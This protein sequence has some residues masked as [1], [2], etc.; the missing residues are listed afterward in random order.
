MEL[1]DFLEILK[2]LYTMDIKHNMSA[3]AQGSKPQRTVDTQEAT[4]LSNV[5]SLSCLQVSSSLAQNLLL[6]SPLYL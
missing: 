3:S 4:V 6:F 5:E 2:L 1:Q